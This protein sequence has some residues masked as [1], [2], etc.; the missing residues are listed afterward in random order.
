M[1]AFHTHLPSISTLRILNQCRLYLQVI[2]LSDIATA[3]GKLILPEAK[4]GVPLSDRL[5]TLLWPAQG[6]PSKVD[7]VVWKYY[8]QHLEDQGRIIQ[9][10]GEW[11]S[12]THQKWKYH[13]DVQ[14]GRVYDTFSDIPV[15]FT[16]ICRGRPLRSG[17]WYDTDRS[18]SCA[19]LPEDLLPVSIIRRPSTDGN[20]FQVLLSPTATPSSPTAAPSS[21]DQQYYASLLP[22]D[23]E[24]P[25]NS[26][27]I[28]EHLHVCISCS[29][30]K[31]A[32]TST[33]PW[34]FQSDVV[35]YTGGHT[36]RGE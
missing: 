21:K 3:D 19:A 5:S 35:H 11:L 26:L 33:S 6:N 22:T 10:L 17:Q 24:V 14:S 8:L 23:S 1:D 28:G 18:Q 31:D 25:Y 9:P 16:P 20:L 2:T 27:L 7:W 36:L 4:Q 29:I 30:D 32:L 34:Q 12:P 13:I 15:V